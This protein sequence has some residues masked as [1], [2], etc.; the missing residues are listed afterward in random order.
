MGEQTQF[1]PGDR[2]PNAGHY[3]EV[4]EDAFHMNIQ[5][6]KHVTLEKGERFPETTNHNR[7]WKKVKQF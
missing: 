4:S 5:D 6:P 2:A 1:E 3:M 7:K